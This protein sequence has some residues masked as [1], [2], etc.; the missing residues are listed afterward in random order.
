MTAFLIKGS[1]IIIK[2]ALF[3]ID[4]FQ[5]KIMSATTFEEIYQILNQ[6][7]LPDIT[8]LVLKTYFLNNDLKFTNKE[9]ANLR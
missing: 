5:D 2:I 1:K 9:L 6:E 7:N 4:F 8:P 3:I